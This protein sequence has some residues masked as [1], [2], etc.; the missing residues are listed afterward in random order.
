MN[1]KI[2]GKDVKLKFKTKFVRLMDEK[3]KVDYEGLE[4]GMGVMHAQMGIAQ[5]SVST[6][7]DI[8]HAA[9]G[10]EYHQDDIDDAVDEYADK[11]GGLR[12][13][14]EQVEEELG[15]SPVVQETI[16]ALREADKNDQNAG[17]N[18]KKPTKK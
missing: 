17:T 7:A 3:Y 4:F 14:F 2:D 9:T 11:E 10:G 13:L 18:Q 6:L 1:F 12:K 15:K 8:I 5:R 16:K